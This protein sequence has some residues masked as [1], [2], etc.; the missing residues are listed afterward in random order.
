[1]TLDVWFWLFMAAWLFLGFFSEYIPGQPY[2]LWRGGRHLVMFI[3]VL[4]L[5]LQV[6][7]GPVK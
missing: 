4:I 6:F 3:V 7:H 5:G 2:P 1:M